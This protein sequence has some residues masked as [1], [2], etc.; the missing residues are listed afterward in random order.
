VPH[1]YAHPFAESLAG[2]VRVLVRTPDVIG[3]AMRVLWFQV[4]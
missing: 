1:S 2:R 4:S 3:M